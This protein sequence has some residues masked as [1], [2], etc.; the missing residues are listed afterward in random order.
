MKDVEFLMENN[1]INYSILIIKFSTEDELDL[2]KY[3]NTFKSIR[4]EE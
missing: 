4:P 1:I 3:P 2:I